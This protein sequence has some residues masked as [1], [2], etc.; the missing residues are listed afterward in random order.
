MVF[1]AGGESH[2]F[3]RLEDG[4]LWRA[5]IPAAAIGAGTVAVEIVPG[6]RALLE[7]IQSQTIAV[8]APELAEISVSVAGLPAD[9]P[10][11]CS[12]C[13]VDPLEP[14]NPG[15]EPVVGAVR[16]GLQV[17]G[18]TGTI[19]YEIQNFPGVL[20][21]ARAVLHSRPGLGWVVTAIAFGHRLDSAQ[22]AY[23]PGALRFHVLEPMPAITV[24]APV[25]TRVFLFHGGGDSG[26]VA[27]RLAS[28]GSVRDLRVPDEG[29]VRFDSLGGR[30]PLPTGDWFKVFGYLPDR[31]VCATLIALRA[32]GADVDLS[33]LPSLPARTMP[34]PAEAGEVHRLY[35]QH[36]D[37]WASSSRG[38]GV[39]AGH[40]GDGFAV[41]DEVLYLSTLDPA[42]MAGFLVLRSGR[43]VRLQVPSVG[44]IDAEWLP[45]RSAEANTAQFGDDA[46]SV[47][48]ELQFRAA[49]G[50]WLEVA[51]GS[52]TVG[53]LLRQPW[54]Q[55]SGVQMRWQI[56]YRTPA[57]AG[58]L[59]WIEPAFR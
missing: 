6:V 18:A 7:R 59:T 23:A 44:E 36:A 5:T 54:L 48:F 53:E 30:Q 22:L 1:A 55:V 31:S 40:H 56:R 47:D 3:E 28:T 8:A 34:L 49:D 29:L 37:G 17:S 12:G 16:E 43:V 15:D 58:P 41:Q 32:N 57:G 33:E 50:K 25:G 35:L 26:S 11:L 45:V 21:G 39:N 46:V 42:S 9:V 38:P 14:P 10:W 19:R 20:G 27:A 51:A 52:A 13:P 2:P 24:R 4:A